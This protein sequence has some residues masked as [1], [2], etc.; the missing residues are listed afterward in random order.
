MGFQFN[1]DYG[2]QFHLLIIQDNFKLIIYNNF[3]GT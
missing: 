1:S 3:Q 2:E